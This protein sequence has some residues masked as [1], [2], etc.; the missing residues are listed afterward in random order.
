MTEFQY[1]KAIN[2]FLTI[3]FKECISV[4]DSL[5][6]MSKN[7]TFVCRLHHYLS[8]EYNHNCIPCNLDSQAIMPYRFLR[9]RKNKAMMPFDYNLY[10]QSMQ[11]AI[12]VIEEI[13]T[14]I[15]F[16]DSKNDKFHNAYGSLAY[17]KKWV[18]FIKHPKHFAVM[19][20][21][22]VYNIT[23]SGV[24]YDSAQLTIGKSFIEKYYM[25]PKEDLRSKLFCEFDGK[26]PILIVY[27][28]ILEITRGYC[29]DIR[30][31]MNYI[32]SYSELREKIMDV[33]TL[34]GFFR[35]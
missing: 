15:F 1:N 7:E 6:M 5:L 14:Y 30:K 28:D 8:H 2:N 17:I 31:F 27:P 12:G 33:A 3:Q 25:A 34:K 20:H 32:E 9:N 13:H 24:S 29:E 22:P 11:G 21:H 23:N 19:S 18:N 4:Y 35:S 10:L 16:K 26:H